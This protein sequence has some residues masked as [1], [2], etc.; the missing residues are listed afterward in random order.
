MKGKKLLKT[1]V[2]KEAYDKDVY[3]RISKDVIDLILEQIKSDKMFNY[4]T[5]EI[6]LP[7]KSYEIDDG[8]IFLNLETDDDMPF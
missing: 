7:I 1:I 3:V 6:I 8:E 2:I 5:S 4:T